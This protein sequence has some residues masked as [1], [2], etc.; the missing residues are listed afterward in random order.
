MASEDIGL[1]TRGHCSWRLMPQRCR[2]DWAVRREL[3]IAQ[4]LVYMACA[5]KSNAVYVAMKRAMS[6]A[7]SSGSAEVPLHLRNATTRL[8]EAEG[9]GEG[10]RY[11]HDEPDAFAAGEDYFPDE[12]S[13]QRFY[14]PTEGVGEPHSR[15]AGATRGLNAQ[16]KTNKT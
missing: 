14:E 11:A 15:K 12:L 5:A 16:A 8:M 7:R 9:F 1:L 4:A 10:Y 3:A 13:P 2:K 6:E